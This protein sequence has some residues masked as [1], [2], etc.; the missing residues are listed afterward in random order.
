MYSSI[1]EIF[2]LAARQHA[3]LRI[4]AT[5]AQFASLQIADHLS[6]DRVQDAQCLAVKVFGRPLHLAW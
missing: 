3:R 5:P 2:L 4:R 1:E 6:R